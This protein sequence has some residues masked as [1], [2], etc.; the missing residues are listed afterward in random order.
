MPAIRDYSYNYVSAAATSIV[1]DAPETLENDLM[2]AV[3]V[4][5]LN[6]TVTPPAAVGTALTTVLTEFPNVGTPATVYM[7]LDTTTN[8]TADGTC[9]VTGLTPYT[10][11]GVGRTTTLATE[12]GTAYRLYPNTTAATPLAVAIY[13]SVYASD[14]DIS[15]ISSSLALRGVA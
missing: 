6:A 15:S 13:T 5:K 4:P 14:V 3:V 10:V 11:T 7:N 1:C 9:N 2:V 8:L 12:A